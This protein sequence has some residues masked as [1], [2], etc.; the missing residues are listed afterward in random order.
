MQNWY[1]GFPET[2][3]LVAGWGVNQE[4]RV[5]G[6]KYTLPEIDLNQGVWMVVVLE[7]IL[8]VFLEL[9]LDLLGPVHEG[10]F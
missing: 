7:G 4:G 2:A 10:S 1:S 3:Q 6:S 9:S 8:W 5:I